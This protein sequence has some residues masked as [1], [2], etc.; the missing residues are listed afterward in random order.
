MFE[1]KDCQVALPGTLARYV[2]QLQMLLA[3]LSLR[4]L[5][6]GPNSALL[7]LAQASTET[8]KR[9]QGKGFCYSITYNIVIHT[10]PA[11]QRLSNNIFHSW[12]MW[13]WALAA[14]CMLASWQPTKLTLSPR[15]RSV[16]GLI[17]LNKNSH[18]SEATCNLTL[19]SNISEVN[20]KPF[21]QRISCR[22]HK[23]YHC[24]ALLLTKPSNITGVSTSEKNSR[25]E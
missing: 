15:S 16:T 20:V 25:P 12:K 7:F 11:I 19:L 3:W 22:C 9:S 10:Y 2:H 13:T 23:I 4:H 24:Q 6:A 14:V 8:W 18:Q 1:R 21:T 17:L 5:H